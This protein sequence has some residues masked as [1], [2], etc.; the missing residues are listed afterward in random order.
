MTN[1]LPLLAARTPHRRDRRLLPGLTL[2]LGVCFGAVPGFS[3]VALGQTAEPSR[4]AEGVHVF[5]E[6]ATPNVL[7]TTYMVVNVTGAEVVGGFYQ[8][9]SSY[10]C[11]SGELVGN[12]MA[13]TVAA[14]FEQPAYPFTLALETMET[15]AAQGIPA[16]QLVP[17]GFQALATPSA[18]DQAVLQACQSAR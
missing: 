18:T 1:A 12:E 3:T 4:L 11:F 15:V 10:D 7:G 6:S 5:G 13:L 9:S 17:S 8:P 2:A 14:N 16:S